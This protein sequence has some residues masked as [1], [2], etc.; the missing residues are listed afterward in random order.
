[1]N[2]T[3]PENQIP[4]QPKPTAGQNKSGK[5]ILI[6]AAAVLVIGGAISAWKYFSYQ[7]L[8]STPAIVPEENKTLTEVT[9]GWQNYQ[10]ETYKFSFNYPKN[11][12]LTKGL[13]ISGSSER[14]GSAENL[15][16]DAIKPLEMKYQ[17]GNERG[18]IIMLKVKPNQPN[19]FEVIT[20]S[21]TETATR[22]EIRV[23]GLKAIEDVSAIKSIDGKYH[24]IIY[25]NHGQNGLEIHYENTDETGTHDQVIDSILSSLKF[26][27]S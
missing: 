19:D 7:K 13:F 10:S 15:F 16:I 4:A 24:T 14:I 5:W 25:L 23:A 22:T 17:T 6:I 20:D 8:Q 18:Y 21:D 9:P 3:S 12:S 1:M 11:F 26:E 2:Q 27:N